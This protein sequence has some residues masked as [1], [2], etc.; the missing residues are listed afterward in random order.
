ME[1]W[2]FY[3]PRNWRT[4]ATTINWDHARNVQ[5]GNKNILLVPSPIFH[6]FISLFHFT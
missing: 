2:I 4:K 3:L 5:T 6:I 1:L